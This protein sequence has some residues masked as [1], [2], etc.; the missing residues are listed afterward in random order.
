MYFSFLVIPLL[1]S[2]D[3]SLA[4][5]KGKSTRIRRRQYVI[6]T[7]SVAGE[8]PTRR[9]YVSYNEGKRSNIQSR[10]QQRSSEIKMHHEFRDLST[11]VLTLTESE[12][13]ELQEDPDVKSIVD[14]VKRYPLHIPESVKRHNRK[15]QGQE[16][17]YGIDMVQAEQAWEYGAT[18]Q[19][20]KVC[21]VDTGVADHPDLLNVSGPNSPLPFNQDGVGHGTHCAGTIAAENNGFGVVG[22]APDAEI[23]SVKVFSDNGQF[24]Y[25]SGILSAAQEC[26]NLGANIISMSLGGPLPNLLELLGY[27]KLMEEQGVISVAAA[28]NFGNGLWSF[29][30]SYPKVLSVAAVDANKDRASFSQFNR[31]VDIAAPG[32][33]VFSTL[34][35]EGRCD[36]CESIGDY[37]YGTISGTSMAC[38][39]VAGVL[40]L[41]RSKFDATPEEYI[42]AIEEAAEDLGS[43]GKD[44]EF[45][46]GLIQA[47]DALMYLEEAS[48]RSDTISI[49]PDPTS[50]LTDVTTAP[51]DAM[52]EEPISPAFISQNQAISCDDNEMLFDFKLVSDSQRSKISWKLEGQSDEGMSLTGSLN[53]S[54]EDVHVRTCIP[55]NCYMFTI[56]NSAGD[57]EIKESYSVLIDGVILTDNV[58]RFGSED[59]LMFGCVV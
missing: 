18:G 50:A 14:D 55:K 39:H 32:V 43:S 31:Q 51:I 26:A 44:R 38:P 19:G 15:L 28:G 41:L 1:L 57:D 29:P 23:I 27:R 5:D 21:V 42:K 25:S 59:I 4:Q 36:I 9:V 20:V 45:G 30:A 48:S 11:F 12:Y 46:H 53:K 8:E 10:L 35:T 17:P 7:E 22:V 3:K 37:V 47:H 54:N 58:G 52:I 34:P 56:I 49:K 24:A 16:V 2:L 33:D 13:R 6:P 40:A